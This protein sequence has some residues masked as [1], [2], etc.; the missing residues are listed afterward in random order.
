MIGEAAIQLTKVVEKLCE[1]VDSLDKQLNSRKGILNR[2]RA[3][4]G[5]CMC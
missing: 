2:V 3:Y 1:K 5:E 4:I